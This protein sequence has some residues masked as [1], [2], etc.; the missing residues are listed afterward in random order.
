MYD[1][2]CLYYVLVLRTCIFMY[3]TRSTMARLDVRK[4]HPHTK[5]PDFFSSF[6]WL[7]ICLVGTFQ[8]LVHA[9][10]IIMS[11]GT[12]IHQPRR[13][14]DSTA[15]LCT[16]VCFTIFSA[17]FNYLNLR[18]IEDKTFR[19]SS[20]IHGH[21]K[22]FVMESITAPNLDEDQVNHEP[23]EKEDEEVHSVKG[24]NCAPYGGPSE[25]DVEE[26]IYWEDIPSDAKFRSPFYDPGKYLTFEPD[27]GGWNNIRMA[28]ETVIV[29]AHAMGR[30]LVLP[31][32]QR[33]YLLGGKFTFNDFFH[34][35]SVALEHDGLDIITTEEFLKREGVTGKLVNL[36]TGEV[37][38]P[39]DDRIQWDGKDPTD[40]KNYLRKVGLVREWR[41]TECVAAFPASS[42]QEDID[43]LNEMMNEVLKNK[44]TPADFEGKP[45][46]VDA[47]AID[48][49]RE[50]LA[51]RD[52]LCIYDKEMQDAKVVHVMVDARTKTRLLIHFYSFLFFENWKHD[53]WGK[54]F[55]R[56][57]IRYRDDLFCAAAT[58]VKA[59][60]D[61]ARARDP[62]KNPHGLFDAFHIRRGDFQYKRTRVEASVIDERTKHTLEPGTTVYIASDERNK[63]F[64]KPL[65][66]KYDVVYLDGKWLFENLNL[67]LH[68]FLHNVVKDY[69]SLVPNIPSNFYGMLD[70]LVAA[71]SRI[72]W[73]T[74]FSTFSG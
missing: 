21:L 10:I 11:S 29:M 19:D 13:L 5:E 33:M 12:R 37:E 32:E 35:D 74:W 26:M 58:I 3:D 56:D 69:L 14:I 64:F 59:V 40:L 18:L 68:R 52:S 60:R 7:H 54:R 27:H 36:S 2:C 46:P 71:K 25:A 48:R 23:D 41:P 43:R 1:V 49:L 61:R 63:D 39:P 38:K 57:H 15:M 55:V 72:F 22:N 28:M 24:L 65:A 66:D 16:L 67:S 73:G 70:A 62:E 20:L 9:S 53:L 51:D 6:V 44:P 45:V 17:F 31:P 4:K 8:T 50:N 42:S 30:T 47:P 34:L